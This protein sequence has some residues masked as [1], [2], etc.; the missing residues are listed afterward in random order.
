MWCWW[1][2]CDRA[3]VLMCWCAADVLIYS[4]DGNEIDADA[5]AD[6][7]ERE[8]SRGWRYE[9]E[10]EREDAMRWYEMSVVVISVD[11]IINNGCIHIHVEQASPTHGCNA[12]SN[13]IKTS[14][15]IW[16]SITL[17]SKADRSENATRNSKHKHLNLKSRARLWKPRAR[18][19]N[20][21]RDLGSNEEKYGNK[22]DKKDN[23]G[24][25]FFEFGVKTISNQQQVAN[26]WQKL[27][28]PPPSFNG[29]SRNWRY[30]FRIYGIFKIRPRSSRD[31]Q[32]LGRVF[33]I[34]AW[35][36]SDF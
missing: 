30:Y 7:R 27:A 35:S 28:P 33:R 17:T 18:F 12:V 10:R 16:T 32:D 26:N 25:T 34:W 21:G 36:E 5:D 29:I 31:F 24:T 9:R 8:S 11:I 2:W 22:K 19:G 3:D 14:I 6:A 15:H 13:P 4:C 1:C 20:L 23:K